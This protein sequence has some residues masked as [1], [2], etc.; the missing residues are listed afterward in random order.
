MMKK[1]KKEAKEF[2]KED[3]KNSSS[4]DDTASSKKL[5]FQDTASIWMVD[6]LQNDS[7]IRGHFPILN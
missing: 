3:S 6:G 5:E 4:K 1:K 2:E 7:E